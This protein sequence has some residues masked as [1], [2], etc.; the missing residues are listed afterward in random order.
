MAAEVLVIAASMMNFAPSSTLKAWIDHI[1]WPGRTMIPTPEGLK[2]LLTGK[3]AYLMAASGGTYSSD[4]LVPADHLIP[5]LKLLLGFI[6]F[7]GISDIETV[8]TEAQTAGSEAVEIGV[9]VALKQVAALIPTG[10]ISQSA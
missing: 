1:V 5:Y 3:K 9:S 6:G 8:R 7:I 10:G 4:P 2:G